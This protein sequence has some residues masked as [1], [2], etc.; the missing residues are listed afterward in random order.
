MYGER[1]QQILSE[2]I[3]GLGLAEPEPGAVAVEQSRSYLDSVV[4]TADFAVAASGAI[5][6]TVAAI[7]EHRGLGP[8]AGAYRPAACPAALQ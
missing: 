2:I 5:G 3:E 6:S 7:G 1:Q 8:Q 4:E